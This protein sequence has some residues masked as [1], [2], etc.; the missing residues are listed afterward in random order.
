MLKA[1][2]I[3]GV[4]PQVPHAIVKGEGVIEH[5]GIRAPAANDRQSVGKVPEELPPI[6]EEGVRALKGDWGYRIPLAQVCNQNC[7]LLGAGSAHFKSAHL[8]LAYLH[9]SDQAEANAAI[10]TRHSLHFH[11]RSWEY[12]VVLKGTKTVQVAGE[13]VTIETGEILEVPPQVRHGLHSRQAPYEGFTFRVP[14]DVADK[15]V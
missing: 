15:F 8:S 13:L 1:K 7:W 14:A 3:L 10:G 2:E 4:K 11:S 6:S 12:Y 5:F 9:F